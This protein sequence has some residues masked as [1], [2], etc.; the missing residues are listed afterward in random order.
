MVRMLREFL[1]QQSGVAIVNTRR[2]FEDR[3]L[4]DSLKAKNSLHY[5]LSVAVLEVSCDDD[6]LNA[7]LF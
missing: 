2:E 7:I 3:R 5:K 6:S 4:W 1:L